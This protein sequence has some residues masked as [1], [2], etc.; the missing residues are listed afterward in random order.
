MYAGYNGYLKSDAKGFEQA[1]EN[2]KNKYND[3]ES[4]AAMR[5][6]MHRDASYGNAIALKD[7][8]A[9]DPRVDFDQIKNE[10]PPT[11]SNKQFFWDE[12]TGV[13]PFSYGYGNDF[14]EQTVLTDTKLNQYTNAE[15]T[16][17][18]PNITTSFSTGSGMYFVDRDSAGKL[19][20][21]ASNYPWT[22]NR[23]ADVMPTYQWDFWKTTQSDRT[24]TDNNTVDGV[25]YRSKITKAGQLNG[26]FDY[27]NPYKK[28][29]SIAIGNGYDF[30]G[31]QGRIKPGIWEKNSAYNWNLMGTNLQ[32]SDYTLDFKVKAAKHDDIKSAGLAEVV[33]NTKVLVKT[34]STEAPKVIEPTSV[35]PV[36]GGWY[37]VSLNLSQAGL[38]VNDQNRLAKIGLQINTGDNTEFIYNVGELSLKPNTMSAPVVNS[39]IKRL[40]NEATIVRDENASI[41]FNWETDNTSNID[42]YEVFYKYDDKWYRVGQ[43]NLTSYYLRD[44]VAGDAL[45]LGIRIKYNSGESSQ[46]FTGT[47]KI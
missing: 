41:R 20:S 9:I 32:T 38:S 24:V 15:E 17:T 10:T 5:K 16:T 28:G 43:T 37:N 4:Y 1:F 21:Y 36:D 13:Y 6:N 31:A 25:K 14:A 40:S 18:A 22:N 23:L 8:L 39:K 35:T 3:E 7:I 26:Y 19:L 46:M 47:F 30:N 45:T 11:D 34:S 27:N 12:N 2:N 42:Y 33:K 29:N 44:L